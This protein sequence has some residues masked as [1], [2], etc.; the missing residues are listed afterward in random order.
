MFIDDHVAAFSV[1]HI[2][3]PGQQP[4]LPSGQEPTV[5]TL[6][7]LITKQT[8][9]PSEILGG[10]TWWF[11]DLPGAPLSKASQCTP[12]SGKAWLP[13]GSVSGVKPDETPAKS[14]VG[15]M[16]PSLVSYPSDCG[17][18]IHHNLA[19]ADSEDSVVTTVRYQVLDIR[20]MNAFLAKHRTH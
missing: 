13:F 15:L 6:R 20:V 10:D 5:S 12:T 3:P 9:A 19:P 7:N 18:S 2:L 17:V 1:V 16:K 11:S 8:W 14:T 4:F